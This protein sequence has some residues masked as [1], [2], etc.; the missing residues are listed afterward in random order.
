M[1][2]RRHIRRM[3]QIN[4]QFIH[5]QSH[6]NQ[7]MANLS[8]TDSQQQQQQQTQESQQQQQANLHSYMGYGASSYVNNH[9]HSHYGHNLMDTTAGMSPMLMP[10]M[11]NKMTPVPGKLD[12]IPSAD[13][14][15][16]LLNLDCSKYNS[17]SAS[18]KA[19]ATTSK[20]HDSTGHE[21]ATAK[22]RDYAIDLNTN[23]AHSGAAAAGYDYNMFDPFNKNM[24]YNNMSTSKALEMF[25]RAATMSFS[26]SFPNPLT[27]SASSSSAKSDAS[28][29]LN[30]A[31]MWNATAAVS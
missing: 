24:A 8:S 22:P 18:N 25:N 9:H 14:Q 2:D 31:Q 21:S 7:Q 5:S 30:S 16:E 10:T 23:K 12:S 11:A 1:R 19:T 6:M 27:S 26:K 15:S 28:A 13:G 4:T 17:M 20:M 3:H 29:D